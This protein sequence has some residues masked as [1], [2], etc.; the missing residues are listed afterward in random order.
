M[1]EQSPRTGRIRA[2]REVLQQQAG[3]KDNGVDPAEL[4][5]PRPPAQS[6]VQVS[7]YN[8]TPL[9]WTFRSPTPTGADSAR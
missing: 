1:S 2:T 5:R 8:Q 3:A 7:R 6:P 9:Q 4:A